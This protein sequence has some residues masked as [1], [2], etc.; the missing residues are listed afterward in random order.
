M[1]KK[2]KNKNKTKIGIIGTSCM[3]CNKYVDVA[4][5]RC[6]LFTFTDANNNFLHYVPYSNY[7]INV[8]ER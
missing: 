4:I 8:P 7:L 3:N 5:V 6:V 2:N 1:S